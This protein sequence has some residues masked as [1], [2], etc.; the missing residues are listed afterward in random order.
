MIHTSFARPACSLDLRFENLNDLPL[1]PLSDSPIWRSTLPSLVLP[2]CVLDLRVENRSDHIISSV[3]PPDLMIH[4]DLPRPL[5]SWISKLHK[6]HRRARIR[7][8][9]YCRTFELRHIWT[10]SD[11]LV[12]EQA[13]PFFFL[14]F[15]GV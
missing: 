6:L 14:L 7:Q 3:S 10:P 8:I 2:A 13:F 1:S 9:S 4:V 5:V 12:P 11:R 15:R